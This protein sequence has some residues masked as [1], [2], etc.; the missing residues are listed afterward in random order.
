[1]AIIGNRVSVSVVSG[2]SR[3]GPYRH[4]ARPMTEVLEGRQLL[5]TIIVNTTGDADG[6]DGSSTLSLRQAIEISN[7]TLAIGSLTAAQSA[8]VSGPLATPNTIDFDIPGTG[9]FTI[10]PAS[11]LPIITSPAVIDGYSEPGAH[12]NTNGPRQGMN[13]VILIELDGAKASGANGLQIQAGQSTVEGLAIGGFTFV[14]TSPSTLSGIG[15]VLQEETGDLIEGN[16]LGTDTTGTAALP[17]AMGLEDT[18]RYA[19]DSSEPTNGIAG[20]NTIGGAVPGAGNVISGNAG[21]GLDLQAAGAAVQA[22]DL[23]Q[24]N[25]IG[26]DVTGSRSLPNGG[27]GIDD[28][29]G[30]STIGGTASGT[31]NVISGNG[32]S[33]LLID[34]YAFFPG[35]GVLGSNALVQG[36]LIGTDATGTSSLSN[37]DDGINDQGIDS[38]I[39]GTASGAGNLLS[40]NGG[41]GL[42]I[43]GIDNISGPQSSDLV[44]GNLIGTDITGSRSLPNGGDGITVGGYDDVIGGTAAG[45]GNTISGNVDDGLDIT[46]LYE[47]VEG[48]DIGT[49]S[50]GAKA[51][52]NASGIVLNS[53]TQDTIGGTASGAGNVISGNTSAGIDLAN[54]I[55]FNY[56]PE[57]SS[58]SSDNLIEGNFI[59]TNAAGTQSL[60]NGT[61]IDLDV[62]DS[63]TIGGTAAGAGNI[64]S[65]NLSDGIGFSSASVVEGGGTIEAGYFYVS[66]NDN[67]IEGNLIGTDPSGTI[68]LG[69]G[70]NGIAIDGGSHNSI[71]GTAAGAGNV[72]AFN[73]GSG[74]NIIALYSASG[75]SAAGPNSIDNTISGNS[76]YANGK[77]GIDLG[78]DGVTPNNPAGSASGPNLLQ[79]Y[80]VLTSATLTASGTLISATLDA[81]PSTSYTVEFF[82]NPVA[83][84]SGFGQGKTYLGSTVATT[85]ATGNVSFSF[86][87][88]LDLLG[89]AISATATDPSGNTS[90]FTR[91]VT[92]GYATTTSLIGPGSIATL[93]V[94]TTFAAVVGA[95]SGGVPTG[96]VDFLQDGVVIGS[97]PLNAS[98]IAVFITKSLSPGTHAITAVYVGDSIHATS[99]SNA[100]ALSVFAPHAFGGPA[101]TSVAATGSDLVTIAFNRGLLPG[102]AEDTANYKIV[103]PGHHS[104][105][106]ESAA[107]DPAT[108]SVTLTTLQKLAPGQS[109]QLTINGETGDRIVDVFG[110]PLNGRKNGKPGHDYVGKFAVKKASVVKVA[111]PSGPKAHA[112]ASKKSH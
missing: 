99:Q 29:G 82:T 57:F 8:Q 93:G 34:A 50:T 109:Y 4:R 1:M 101:V 28:A 6:A 35:S 16:F 32:L 62:S 110:I 45:A 46:G 3:R 66:S 21:T 84:P 13:T 92:V 68:A 74:I 10:S 105:T 64:I 78:G 43:F 85:D 63:N 96:L 31:G 56:V 67:I 40:G 98:G 15:I 2:Q 14:S 97:A 112:R 104:I 59:G 76:I 27:N 95:T 77:L 5:A 73:G 83:D 91:D 54:G 24:G 18:S 52:P 58:N 60:P 51:L 48:N 111:H 70:D 72:I 36:N 71:G 69:N 87:S 89:Q 90:E 33:G 20:L 47:L 23:I 86:N 81:A 17:N 53:S 38:T 9:P 11:A 12:P 44:Q 61:G 75:T 42:D 25:F 108:D 19:F 100:V 103:G 26:L 107:Y 102:P 94:P 37:V 65:G 80:P 30:G 39:G 22:R 41:A 55:S 7:G 79:P 49:D 88:G 106:V